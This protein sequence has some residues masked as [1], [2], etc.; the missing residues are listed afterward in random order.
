MKHNYFNIEKEVVEGYFRIQQELLAYI[1][2]EELNKCHRIDF[3]GETLYLSFYDNN[4]LIFKGYNDKITKISNVSYDIMMP[5]EFLLSFSQIKEYLPAR[6]KRWS[7][8]TYLQL[9]RNE[10]IEALKLD[11]IIISYNPNMVTFVAKWTAYNIELSM[12]KDLIFT[13]INKI[14]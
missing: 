10:I 7:T 14:E 8:I 4:C 3:E 1:I 5:N 6:L 11:R 13:G 9:L 2:F 12:N